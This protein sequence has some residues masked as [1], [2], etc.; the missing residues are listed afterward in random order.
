[1]TAG[2]GLTRKFWQFALMRMGV[3][4]GEASLSPA[5]YSLIADYFRPRAAIHGDQRLLDGNLYR[6]R[7]RI[8]PRRLG[9]AV[10]GGSESFFLP[11]LGAVRSWQ[12]VFF[13]VGLPGLLVAPP[14]LLIREPSRKGHGG[15]QQ[16]C[17][18]SAVWSYFRAQLVVLPLPQPRRR[19]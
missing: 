15:S 7:S 2:C 6:V 14:M 1:M 18:L 13:L 4:V 17:R 12:L 9:R 8:H 19:H 10:R 3:G 5:A 16:W 11:L